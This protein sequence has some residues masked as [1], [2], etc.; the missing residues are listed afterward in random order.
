[1]CEYGEPVYLNSHNLLYKKF[2]N[3]IDHYFSI[4]TLDDTYDNG[5]KVLKIQVTVKLIDDN[6]INGKVDFNSDFIQ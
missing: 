5:N 2:I 3:G 6:S 1:M 4:R